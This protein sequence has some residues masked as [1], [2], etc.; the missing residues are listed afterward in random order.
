[1]DAIDLFKC[2]SEPV[3]LRL[4]CL[5]S[6]TEPELCVCDLV[7]VLELPQGTVSRHLMQL[8]LMGLVKVRRSGVWMYYTLAPATSSAHAA[9]LD[10]LK[11]SSADEP[12]LARD[13]K[14]YAKLKKGKSLACCSTPKSQRSVYAKAPSVVVKRGASK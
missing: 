12:L 6:N 8:R 2:L 10:W 14:Q 13:L 1:M 9:A 5:L 3:R 11:S 7:N 4:L